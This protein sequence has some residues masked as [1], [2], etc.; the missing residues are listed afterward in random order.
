M[1]THAELASLLLKDAAIFFR[2]IAEQ[3]PTAQ[4]QMNDNAAIYEQVSALIG[5][6]PK[7][8]LNGKTHANMAASLLNDAAG[9][10]RKLGE[11]NEPLKDQMEHNA[12]VFEQMGIQV[13]Q[14]PLGV[15]KD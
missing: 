7:G 5:N 4:K 9:F 14:N 6:D 8:I 13:S 2:S 3:N 11:K 15:M 10:F 12:L 1:S